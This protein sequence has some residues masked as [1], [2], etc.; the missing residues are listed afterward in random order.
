MEHL[1]LIIIYIFSQSRF[2]TGHL[3]FK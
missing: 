1:V 2:R 3:A